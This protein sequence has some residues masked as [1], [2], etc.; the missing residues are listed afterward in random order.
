[1]ATVDGEL[2][3]FT[4]G[5]VVL[6]RGKIVAVGAGPAPARAGMRRIDGRGCLATPGLVNVHHH[7]Y[8]WATRGLA[9]SEDLFGWLDELYPIWA[10]IDADLVGDTT[11]AGLAWLGLSG[12]TTTADLHHVFPQGAGDMMAAQ[13]GAARRI[14][15]RM[16]ICRGGMDL[17]RSSGGLAPDSLVEETG[18]VIAGM[19][20]AI[21]DFHDPSP[22]AMV[23]VALAPCSPF[24]VSAQLMVETAAL[25]RS[26]GVRLHTQLAESTEEERY[27]R[28]R[29]GLS[30]LVYLDRLGWLGDDVWLAHGVHLPDRD[31]A[32]LAEANT[33]L[34]HCPSSN[35]RLGAGIAPVRR[36]LDAGI[37]V[38]LGVGGPASQESG[39]LIEELRQAVY[40]ARAQGGPKALTVRE[41][42][43]M[44]T[45]GGAHCLGRAGEIGSLEVGKLADVALWRLDGLG[46]SGIADPVAAL[47]LGPPAPLARL[48][49]QG[50]EVVVDAKLRTADLGELSRE[51]DESCRRLVARR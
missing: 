23:R 28:A 21:I 14:G 33:S 38:G 46:H 22:E 41:A 34:A 25:A 26:R 42:L 43:W 35:A 27:C 2:T 30:P 3:E 51:L 1:M 47:V 19:D 10:G 17:G 44:A 20:A 7:L 15:L 13:V 18:K 6:E 50:N 5:H 45:M 48:I 29:F 36:M 16:Q 37:P 31:I 40:L 8:Q 32:V 49:V 11:A 4:D 39:L 12:C 9:Q 24:S